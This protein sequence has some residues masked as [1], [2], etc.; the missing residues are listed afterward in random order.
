MKNKNCIS[1]I[2]VYNYFVKPQQVPLFGRVN[3]STQVCSGAAVEL[4]VR[5]T[6]YALR[7]CTEQLNRRTFEIN[8]FAIFDK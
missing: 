7:A 3:L 5:N 1:L 4:L 8:I 6:Q 2:C